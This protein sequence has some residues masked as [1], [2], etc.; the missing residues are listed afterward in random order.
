MWLIGRRFLQSPS[1][2][3]FSFFNSCIRK[4][5]LTNDGKVTC[6]SSYIS[7]SRF[8][9]LRFSILNCGCWDATLLNAEGLDWILVVARCCQILSWYVSLLQQVKVIWP[10]QAAGSTVEKS[11]KMKQLNQPAGCLV[12]K[13]ETNGGNKE[14]MERKESHFQFISSW[15]SWD[16]FS[17]AAREKSAQP[18]CYC[19]SL[20]PPWTQ[21]ANRH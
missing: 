1:E 7:S 15:W 16:V 9:R 17:P 2:G 10:I 4:M 18:S 5:Y 6:S 21:W 13:K 11:E 14:E 19:F 3:C 8:A 12:L 20:P